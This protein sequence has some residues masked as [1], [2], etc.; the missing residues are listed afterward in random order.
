MAEVFAL[1]DCNNF[2]VSCER[3]FNPCLNGKPVVVLSNNDGCVVSRSQE[4]K[5]LG[6]KT[7]TPIHE[8]ERE[9]LRRGGSALS[10]NYALYGD[11]SRRVMQT[12]AMFSAEIEV[13]S[14][15]ESFLSLTGS[16][17]ELN[18]L[19]RLMQ[20]TVYQHTGIP[21]SVGAGSTK[22]L[23]KAANR[24]AKKPGGSGLFNIGSGDQ[25]REALSTLPVEDV[26]GIGWQYSR[27]LR[28]AGINTAL[29]LS[30]ADDRWVRKHL[31][32]TGLRLVNELRGIP[33][34]TLEEYPPSKK[35]ACSSR[36][37]SRPVESLQEMKEAVS[38]YAS[39]AAGRIRSQ[40]S[41]ASSITVYI[42]TNRFRDEPQYARSSTAVLPSPT[43]YTPAIVRNA[44]AQLVS[45]YRCGYRYK[46]AGVI[47]SGLV[48][49]DSC[50][51]NLFS[52]PGT[53]EKRD[54]LS[55]VMDSINSRY[56][57]NS[58]QLASDGLSGSWH[59]KRAKL[60]PCYTTRWEELLTVK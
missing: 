11:M 30:R 52:E 53:T 37:F 5:S 49:K 12:L 42:C 26:W 58:V 2:Y 24:I 7:G 56:G 44:L 20:H 27:F 50:Q 40:G 35:E 21:V 38:S 1:V 32:I 15:D 34:M 10:S 17:E 51:L 19:C 14:I 22:T 57:K 16:P 31:T 8:C 59:M 60:S 54:T 48:P 46:K 23:A 4:A 39:S 28:L 33:C 25:M 41:A 18:S 6:I 36:S 47:L 45:I 13:Y 9:I 29:D 3:V 43:D 55:K